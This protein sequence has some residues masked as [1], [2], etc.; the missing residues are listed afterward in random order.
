MRSAGCAREMPKAAGR[1]G[2]SSIRQFSARG[3]GPSA[4]RRAEGRA[5]GGGPPGRVGGVT[6]DRAEAGVEWQGVHDR[7]AHHVALRVRATADPRTCFRLIPAKEVELSLPRVGRP[8][9]YLEEDTCAFAHA[10]RSTCPPRSRAC[11]RWVPA[12]PR[13]RRNRAGKQKRL[14]RKAR[15]PAMRTER[16]AESCASSEIGRAHV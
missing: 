11:S 2:S 16:P 7:G 9:L 6:S 4:R 15:R 14:R 13:P 10:N 12:P 5:R 8:L 1:G 3:G